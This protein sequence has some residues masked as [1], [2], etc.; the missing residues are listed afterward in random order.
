MLLACDK[1]F[2]HVL[3]IQFLF[4]TEMLLQLVLKQYFNSLLLPGT[5]IFITNFVGVVLQEASKQE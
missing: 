4:M 2:V 3:K 5:S 1:D